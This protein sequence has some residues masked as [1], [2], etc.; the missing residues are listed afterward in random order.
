MQ[1]QCLTIQRIESHSV[2]LWDEKRC[3]FFKNV[4]FPK[5][6]DRLTWNF[7]P[8]SPFIERLCCML[9]FLK[10]KLRHTDTGYIRNSQTALCPYTTCPNIFPTLFSGQNYPKKWPIFKKSA[11]FDKYRFL[12]FQRE[13]KRYCSLKIVDFTAFWKKSGKCEK[14][15]IFDVFFRFS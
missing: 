11:S 3:S 1:N 14:R 8:S 5:G 6:N 12:A 10:K 15:R 7:E 2:L 4:L 9:V 13:V